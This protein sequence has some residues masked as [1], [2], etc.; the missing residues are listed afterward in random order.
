M[1]DDDVLLALLAVFV[2]L[3]F[4]SIGGGTSILAGIQHQAVD[5]HHWVT[6][7]EFVDMFAISR[8][9]PGPGSMLTTLIGW[10][11]AGWSGALVA[12]LALCSPSWL[13]CWPESSSWCMSASIAT[14]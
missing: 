9:A 11:I 4:A 12:T 10:H 6:S 1:H 2:P 5:V 7:R 13:L 3:S 14:A 8:V